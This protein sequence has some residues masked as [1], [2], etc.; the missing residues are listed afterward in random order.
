MYFIFGIKIIADLK[1]LRIQFL[2][3]LIFS[4]WSAITAIWSQYPI[5]TL[6]RSVFFLINAAGSLF[7][8]AYIAKQNINYFLNSIL[9]LNILIVFVTL[10]SLI[11]NVPENAWSG[12]HGLGFMGFTNHQNKLGQYIFLTASPLILFFNTKDSKPN[13][14]ILISIL[15]IFN[16][17]LIS[18]SVSRAAII[19]LF[20][21]WVIYFIFNFSY[22]KTLY[23]SFIFLVIVTLTIVIASNL[24]NKDQI[25]L[26]KHENSFGER[27]FQTISDS[28]Y[29]ALNGGLF[30]LGYGI[31]DER[32]NNPL[33]GYY[34]KTSEGEIYRREK[35][36]SILAI[37]EE[38][39]IVGLGLFSLV[40]LY[41]FKLL[42]LRR[43][44]SGAR[45]KNSASSNQKSVK[46]NA[47]L[48]TRHSSLITDHS[49]HNFY[50]IFIFA[51]LLSSNIYAQIES[52]WIGIGSAVLPFYFIFTGT[53][54]YNFS[55]N[56]SNG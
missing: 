1:K 51:F 23:L 42:W 8:G 45:I 25:T 3:I 37:I 39:G 9:I 6:Q 4:I 52:W 50:L 33:L 55:G 21:V 22:V 11:F 5:F 56:K 53:I 10:V 26:V 28:W 12:G 46:S 30:G 43:K 36:V 13:K 2:F 32:Y 19:S 17:I 35:T 47:S 40:I 31:S 27:R 44:E 24:F 48:I 38:T 7:I 16:L 18:L 41:P 20:I 15:I 34:D 14:N 49:L 54:L 29:S